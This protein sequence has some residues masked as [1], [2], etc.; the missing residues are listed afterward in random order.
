MQV[1]L[2]VE[3]AQAPAAM[4]KIGF[5]DGGVAETEGLAAND[6]HAQQHRNSHCQCAAV[7]HG[8]DATRLMP[9]L[10]L[11]QKRRKACVHVVGALT[12]GDGGLVWAMRHKVWRHGLYF[13]CCAA[14]P[15]AH[16][17]FAQPL[18]QHHGQTQCIGHSLR[19]GD[20]RAKGLA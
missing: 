14:R 4:R 6:R 20:A 3:R 5:A 19:R 12:V 17:I 15:I 18:I 2:V 16:V 10:H 9:R 13:F 7:S 11:L 1:A 8:D